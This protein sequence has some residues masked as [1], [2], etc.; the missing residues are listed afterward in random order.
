MFAGAKVGDKLQLSW[1]DTQ[2]ET[3]SIETLIN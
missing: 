2:G 3:D 1:V